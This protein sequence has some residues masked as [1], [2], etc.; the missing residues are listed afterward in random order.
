M[1]RELPECEG[2]DRGGGDVMGNG[3][4]ERYMGESI[5]E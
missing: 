3:N 2:D 1:R 5:F 4:G